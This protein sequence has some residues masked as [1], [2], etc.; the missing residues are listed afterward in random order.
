MKLLLTNYSFQTASNRTLDFCAD[1]IL[2][3]PLVKIMISEYFAVWTPQ[4]VDKSILLPELSKK[5]NTKPDVMPNRGAV[6]KVLKRFCSK[7]IVS[8]KFSEN[9]RIMRTKISK[10]RL[11]MSP[12]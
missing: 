6:Q 3:G 9:L 5:A 12:S 7:F 1:L 10:D 2:F 8:R 11:E 4:L